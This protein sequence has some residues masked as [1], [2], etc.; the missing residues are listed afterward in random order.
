MM[1]DGKKFWL[2]QLSE[3]L[4]ECFKSHSVTLPL[5]LLPLQLLVIAHSAAMHVQVDMCRMHVR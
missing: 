2:M 4:I 5:G 3:R 1:W